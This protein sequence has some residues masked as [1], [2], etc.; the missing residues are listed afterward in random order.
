MDRCA[1]RLIERLSETYLINGLEHRVSASIGLALFPA[2]GRDAE[3]LLAHADAAMYQA[4]DGGRG[5]HVFFEKRMNELEE[6]MEAD[7]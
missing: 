7:Y 1:R 6:Q 4:K 3:A 2:D 5:R